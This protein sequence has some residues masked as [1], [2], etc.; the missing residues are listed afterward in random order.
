MDWSWPSATFAR[1][2]W[3]S[4]VPVSDPINPLVSLF[5]APDFIDDTI[6]KRDLVSW[7]CLDF[8]GLP[9]FYFL[10]I[11]EEIIEFNFLVDVEAL[12]PALPPAFRW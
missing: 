11:I 7:S 3:S 5:V 2:S 1:A 10:V 9:E 4:L 8:I 6:A 12:P